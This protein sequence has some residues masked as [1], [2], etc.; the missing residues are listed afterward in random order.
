M[1]T[2]D[3]FRRRQKNPVA[4][5]YENREMRPN[6]YLIVT[7]GT[8]TEPYYFQGLSDYITKKHGGVIDVKAPAPSFDIQGK[9]QCTVSLVEETAKIVNRAHIQYQHVWVIFDKDDF[10]DFD[11]AINL[12]HQ[13]GFEVAWSNQCFEYWLYLHFCYCSSALHRTELVKKL[14]EIFKVRNIAPD[15]YEKNLRNIFDLVTQNGSLR[16]AIGSA[17]R[18]MASYKRTELPSLS[19]P[20]TTVHNLIMELIPFISELIS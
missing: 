6:S 15:G 12:A 7:E 14:D 11:A 13:K 1:G 9:G 2:D 8:R 18:I 4:R 19:D 3:F 10:D 20:G 16:S 5:R 17:K